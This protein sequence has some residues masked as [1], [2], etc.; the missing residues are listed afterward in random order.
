MSAVVKLRDRLKSAQKVKD[1]GETFYR[2]TPNEHVTNVLKKLKEKEV[3]K[4]F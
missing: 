3:I 1:R 2:S 4:I